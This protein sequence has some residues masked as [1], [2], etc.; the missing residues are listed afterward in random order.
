MQKVALPILGVVVLLMSGCAPHD[1]GH[2]IDYYAAQEG[3]RDASVRRC[4]AAWYLRFD[5]ATL[6]QLDER[7]KADAPP[8]DSAARE[9]IDAAATI[10][11]RT[12]SGELDRL[13]EKARTALAERAVCASN[14]ESLKLVATK[15]IDQ[16]S[17]NEK[18]FLRAVPAKRR[19]NRL[20]ELRRNV[21]P[22]PDD[23]ARL[24]R[25]TLLLGLSA[26]AVMGVDAKERELR[27]AVRT[28]SARSLGPVA[29]WTPPTGGPEETII[30]N[31]P[32]I[33]V[34]WPSARDYP[35]DYDRIGRVALAGAREHIEVRV[36]PQVPTVYT[37][38]SSALIHGQQFPQFEY[39]WW[40]SDRPA[41]TPD[42][43]AAG[44]VDGGTLRLTLDSNGRPAIAEVILNCG[45]GHEVY[46]AEDVEAAALAEFGA[47]LAN[48]R[49]AVEKP[50]GDRPILVA[51]TFSRGSPADHPVVVLSAGRHEPAR[52]LVASDLASSAKT[53][54]SHTY[55]L[56]SYDE[57]DRLA[58]GD[59][60]ASMF[61]PDGLVHF[62]GRPEGF[63]LAPTGMLS[64]GQP[65][66]R[67]TQ[68]I[69]WDEYVFDDPELLVNT[70]R[71][72]KSF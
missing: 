62:A 8:T 35:V 45:C 31:A 30:R 49:F 9:V 23:R 72:P 39:V 36:E 71:L 15:Q 48:A 27:T 65:R 11:K 1:F 57:L 61:G 66:K 40:F 51:G 68:R 26:P 41:M 33:A 47:P 70:L 16:A 14:P 4:S 69:R 18:T 46:V 34:E 12:I 19:L 5:A 50:K 3:V 53:V 2:A 29:L 58:L 32:L 37:Y 10:A 67:G 54:E 60:V 22:L 17:S 28:R 42:D 24:S 13:S 52:V 64:A 7:V 6:H 59:G 38:S 55:D 63:L 21:E 56:R 44:H 25:Q 20:R 43:V